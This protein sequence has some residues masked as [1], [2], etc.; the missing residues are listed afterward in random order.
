MKVIHDHI[1]YIS[2]HCYNDNIIYFVDV[3]KLKH[4]IIF[5][6]SGTRRDFL[7][8]DKAS[9]EIVFPGVNN[10]NQINRVFLTDFIIFSLL[11]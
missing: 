7:L 8:L 10:R 11:Y 4:I 2:C 1:S 6:K 5:P 3:I 9:S